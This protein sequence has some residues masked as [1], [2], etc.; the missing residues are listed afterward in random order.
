MGLRAKFNLAILAAFA[1]GFVAAALVLYR[2]SISNARQE[3]LQN[4]RIMMAAADAIRK[5]TATD[6]APLL[7]LTVDG[8]FVAENVPDYAA[9]KNFRELQADFPGFSYREP[10]LNP[11]NLANRAQDWEADIINALRNDP[12]RREII[13][14]RDTPNGATLYLA[15]PISVRDETCLL[16]HGTVTLAPPALTR[17]YGT[18]NGFGWKLHETIGAQVLSVP[19]EL[20]LTRGQ[21]TF[22]VSLGILAGVFAVVLLILNILLHFLVLQPVAR[23]SAIAEAVSLGQ[24]GVETYVKPGKDEISSL[25]ISFDRMRQSLDHAMQMLKA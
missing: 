15:R 11:T 10:A 1:V 18:T 5:Y 16:C 14:E 12:G 6:L 4:A 22:L 13:A 25:S 8:K 2:V 24:E 7:P 21:E 17:T 3:V 23:V 9:Q 19:M 20:A